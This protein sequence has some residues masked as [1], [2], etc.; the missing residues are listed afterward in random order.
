MLKGIAYCNWAGVV[1]CLA[2]ILE[3]HS[4]VK[5]GTGESWYNVHEY[6]ELHVVSREWN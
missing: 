2:P 5:E 1:L 4:G 3:I 6:L